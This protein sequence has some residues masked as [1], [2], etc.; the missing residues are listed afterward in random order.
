MGRWLA[1]FQDNTLETHSAVTDKTDK[2]SLMPVMAVQNQG[3]LERKTEKP[4]DERW[5][6]E[7]ASQGYVWCL[8]CKHFDSV[9]CNHTDNPFHTIEKQPLAPRK[10][11]WFIDVN[12][13][14]T[15]K[16]PGNGI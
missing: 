1:E 10:C 9:N 16:E 14:I 4:S 11:Q 7:L 13:E 6:P 3:H 2:S 12:S 8:D 15:I 5:N